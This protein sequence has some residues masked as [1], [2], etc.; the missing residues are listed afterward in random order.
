MTLFQLL[1]EIGFRIPRKPQASTAVSLFTRRPE[2]FHDM[3]FFHVT[4]KQLDLEQR[5]QTV[6]CP[7][8]F[9]R[10]HMETREFSFKT[11]QPHFVGQKTQLDPIASA[12]RRILPGPPVPCSWPL[13]CIFR[14]PIASPCVGNLPWGRR[15]CVSEV[16]DAGLDLRD[17]LPADYGQ[18]AGDTGRSRGDTAFGITTGG[19]MKCQ[20]GF[21]TQDRSSA[22]RWTWLTK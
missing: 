4:V 17:L 20:G 12:F 16:C 9:G 14:P 6:C 5:K 2:S 7:G 18:G 3:R 13:A 11:N 19:R 8:S 15:A 1:G 10:K 22:V 21:E